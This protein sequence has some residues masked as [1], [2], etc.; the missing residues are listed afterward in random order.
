M[1]SV[2]SGGVCH[3]H[4]LSLCVTPVSPCVT[5]PHTPINTKGTFRVFGD[6]LVKIECPKCHRKVRRQ[7]WLS[8]HEIMCSVCGI[9]YDPITGEMFEVEPSAQ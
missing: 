2:G 1:W 6:T 8:P 4:R 5:H 9:Q 7:L 3:T